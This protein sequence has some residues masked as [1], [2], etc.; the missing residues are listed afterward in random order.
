MNMSQLQIP[1]SAP[2]QRVLKEAEDKEA[3]FLA[4]RLL[5]K[6]ARVRLSDVPL[7]LESLPSRPVLFAAASQAG[8]FAAISRS[9]TGAHNIIFASLT[10]LRTAFTT[11]SSE[12]DIP[13]TPIRTV[14]I[15]TPANAIHFASNESKLVVGLTS[16]SILVYD[17][18][19]LASQS[20]EEVSP[21][22]VFPPSNGSAP[23]EIAANPADLPDLVAVLY[24]PGPSGQRVD[25]LDIQ[26][27]QTVGAWTSGSTAETTPSCI[28]WSPKGKQLAIGLQSG[29]I[30]TYSPSDTSRPKTL[31]PRPSS[32]TGY[33]VIG[34]SWLSN[35]DF[36]GI[37]A[38]AGSLTAESDQ[39]HVLQS[40]DTKAN[41]ITEVKLYAPYLPF[42]GL[43]PPGSFT[44]VLKQW[45]P[46][47]F[48][49][50]VGDG[51]SSDIGLLG[52]VADA[53]GQ[54][55][56]T[57]FSLEETSTPSVPLDQDSN[58]TVPIGLALDLTATEEFK[59]KTVSG[60][61]TMLP[62]P[63]IM[64]LYASD[65]TVVAWNVLNTLATPYPG[66][67]KTASTGDAMETITVPETQLSVPSNRANELAQS[68]SSSA[69]TTSTQPTP[70]F[71]QA[72]SA[73][74]G[75][76][77]FG[78]P[79]TFG[80]TAFSS[81][82]ASGQPAA[83]GG[84]SSNTPSGQQSLSSGFGAFALGGNTKFGQTSAFGSSSLPPSNVM[85]PPISPIPPSPMAVS[86]S[87]SE[88]PMSA[89]ADFGGGGFGGMSLGGSSNPPDSAALKPGVFGTFAA[90][91]NQSSSGFG[92]TSSIESSSS[93]I[94]P[95]TGGFGAFASQGP[96]TFGSST[97][98]VATPSTT[99]PPKSA[100]SAFGA[101]GF[102]ASEP[103][104]TSSFGQTSFGAPGVKSAFG[105]SSFAQSGFG[106]SSFGSTAKPAASFNSPSVNTSVATTGGFAAFAQ[107]GTTPF[108]SSGSSTVSEG[109][110]LGNTTISKSDSTSTSTTAFTSSEP[111]TPKPTP[112]VSEPSMPS[113]SISNAATPSSSP[114]ISTSPGPT[115]GAFAGLTSHPTGFG[116]VQPG[117]GAFGGLG[118]AEPSSSPFFNPPKTPTAS[119]FGGAVSAFSSTP[120]T[121]STPKP[122]GQGSDKPAFG[123]TS[124][125]G[126]AR[127]TPEKNSA[128]GSPSPLGGPSMFGKSVFSSSSTPPATPPVAASGAFS[129]F[130]GSSGFASFSGGGTKSFGDL[131][132]GDKDDKS[133]LKESTALP[134]AKS[135]AD[136]LQLDRALSTT[137]PLQ[138]ASSAEAPRSV[139]PT[140][141]E[142]SSAARE[143]GS[144][145]DEDG[146]S[147]EDDD[148]AISFLSQSFSED[149]EDEE[150][151]EDQD[152]DEDNEE[153]EED[154]EDED[155]DLEEVVLPDPPQVKFE[156][157][158]KEQSAEERETPPEPEIHLTPSSPT[159]SPALAQATSSANEDAVST[160]PP[161]T[162]DKLPSPPVAS[163]TPT[164]P[165]TSP[166]SLG[167]GRPSTR[168]TRSS[169]LASA[170]ISGDDDDSDKTIRPVANTPLKDTKVLN[171]SPPPR[172]DVGKADASSATPQANLASDTSSSRPKTPPL[173]S[174]F[175]PPMPKPS[176]FVI[177]PAGSTASAFAQPTT[178]GSNSLFGVTTPASSN[179]ASFSVPFPAAPPARPVLTPT[180]TAPSPPPAAKEVPLASPTQSTA[181]QVPPSTPVLTPPPAGFF[182]QKS[183]GLAPAFSLGQITPSTPSSLI[184]PPTGGFFGQKPTSSSSPVTPPG[185][186]FSW[187]KPVTSPSQ[188]T[189]FG[190]TQVVNPSMF[191]KP[192]SSP[193]SA[194]P[195]PLAQIEEGMQ[196][197]CANLVL[198]MARELETMKQLGVQAEKKKGEH[199][200]SLNVSR[201][202]SDLADSTKFGIADAEE[203]GRLLRSLNTV[204]VDLKEMRATQSKSIRDLEAAMLKVSMRKE[205][206]VRFS[207][208]KDDAE[209]ANILKA[210]SLGPEH[211]ETQIHLRRGVRVLRDRIQKLEDHMHASKKRLGQ[212][213]LGKPGVRPPSLDTINRT[214]RNI[215]LAI[216]QQEGDVDHLAARVSRLNIKSSQSGTAKLGRLP[217]ELKET[218]GK[219]AP[220]V[221]PN[222]AA[223]T[224]AALNAERAAQRLKG[225][226]LRV[227][228]EPLL[229][230]QAVGS[231]APAIEFSS[232]QKLAIASGSSDRSVFMAKWDA[233]DTPASPDSSGLDG[234]GVQKW[235]APATMSPGSPSPPPEHPG[236][237]RRETSSRHAK[238]VRRPAGSSGA[239]I[240][241]TASPPSNFSWGPVPTITPMKTLSADVRSK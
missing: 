197:E 133:V 178:L 228:K 130:S 182:G 147:A 232:P 209:F 74:L 13:F 82:R 120:S 105:Q 91:T 237:R 223:T 189:P 18:R 216:S 51:T 241:A 115:T 135:H 126:A 95:A 69:A 211:L 150:N 174:A 35:T 188:S 159:A 239:T 53:E 68:N 112:A 64:Y 156:E 100:S 234:L 42:P 180:S 221:T 196:K 2:V 230:R 186:T 87:T 121:P 78:K 164:T 119:A 84:T 205:E 172:S 225:A 61:D 144:S 101:S 62:P 33:S 27:S 158:T 141:Q 36:Y 109:N 85:Q 103:S 219:R 204:V 57:N 175:G 38:P 215:D 81:G 137:A 7:Q 113:K 22:H 14:P 116:P 220:T 140:S 208:A 52:C 131:L 236:L 213:K 134:V 136:E 132:R 110:T 168:P 129:A 83:F 198:T 222:V 157:D 229:N 128:F 86:T 23:R 125:L 217:M 97:F 139:T 12:G 240:T 192:T 72:S 227:R 122:L 94:K 170:P 154:E 80:S 77:A 92:A 41:T 118:S 50:F 29:D 71:G 235:G 17:V 155:K 32:A 233:R 177:T 40:L 16:G 5:N 21:S 44:V 176:P 123:S 88:E 194:L 20:S 167:I 34:L 151:V 111:T 162:P 183:P 160:T 47:K 10:S 4:L 117:S 231:S 89:S 138:K 191:G 193:P 19:T 238:P 59:H 39:L 185:T 3:D 73:P 181:A 30:V 202:A 65:G 46:A 106:T 214:Y 203:F 108:G 184:T 149:E 45:E 8:F 67:I 148:D 37:Y 99:E 60:E 171:K 187:N 201:K 58:D 55:S 212:L 127:T 6:Q 165:S 28:S 24:E 153:D 206:V 142:A 218:P 43:R 200:Q 90:P 25:L 98:S 207:K 224:A 11:S 114:F 63:P 15:S 31:V 26:N 54:E 104:S 145:D 102:G 163:P 79:S 124:T 173:L 199:Y 146:E 190:Q 1:P 9:S 66:M 75:E 169:P 226:L 96:S 166:F 93:V 152:V 70:G 161:G 179:A 195:D 49:L 76:S 56:W 143:E 107:A 210:R 48:L